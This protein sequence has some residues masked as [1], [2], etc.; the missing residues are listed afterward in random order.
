ME[1]DLNID[2]RISR[3]TISQNPD[4]I[5]VLIVQ[6]ISEHLDNQAPVRRLQLKR[7]KTTFAKPETIQLIKQ[8]D[9]AMQLAKATEDDEDIRNFKN[10]RNRAHKQLARDKTTKNKDNLKSASEDDPK[11]QWNIMKKT[12]GWRKSTTPKVIKD[13]GTT[14]TS[15]K[16]IAQ[17]IN[18]EQILKNIKLQRN[19]PTTTTDPL[20]NYRK[21]MTNKN[22][23]F[24]LKTI[25][26]Q[27]LRTTMKQMKATNSTSWDNISMK[28]LKNV[29]KII[30]PALLN[31]I[32][33]SIQLKLYPDNLK[34]SK[35]IPL[36]KEGK[37]PESPLSYRLINILPSIGKIL[38]KSVGKQIVEYLTKNQITPHSHHGG[39]PHRSTTTALMTMLDKWQTAYENN[40]SF[41]IIVLDQSSAYDI[42]NHELLIAKM[43]ILGFN[44]NTLEYF[45][46][47][48]SSRRQAVQVDGFASEHLFIEKISVIQGSVLSCLMYMIYVLDLPLIFSP[49]KLT[50]QEEE[51]TTDPTTS[52]FVDDAVITVELTPNTNH[53]AKVNYTMDEL[54]KYTRANKLVL[55]KDKTKFLVIT[56]NQEIR[57]KL[58]LAT[59]PKNILPIR[60]FK[61]LGVPIADNLHWLT[62][63]ARRQK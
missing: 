41:A 40:K 5:S 61:F 35:A 58:Y 10:L 25:T 38:D 29:Q 2:T 9:Q 13:N 28:T 12:I 23:T 59:Y 17:V 42:I 33:T 34:G 22:T 1:D 21:L 3:A 50:L 15:P 14:I 54:E 8:R 63:F 56:K 26:M 47:Y 48:L 36:L 19:I 37:E 24:E 18:R 46:S 51:T 49:T 39:R 11:T 44:Q 43:K 55:N 4:E 53:Q 7:R 30:E 57:N 31:L 62:F 16:E 52:T 45:T 6:A 60:N 20:T 32:N 27:E